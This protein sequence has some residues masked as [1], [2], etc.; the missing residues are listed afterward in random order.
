M[1]TMIYI[2]LLGRLSVREYTAVV[3]GFALYALETLLL[4]VISFLPKALIRY[5]YD[6]SR[7]AFHRFIL[8]SEPG[9]P[10]SFARKLNARIRD[11]RDFDELCTIW[12]YEHEEHVVM[13]ADGYIL[14]LH[15]LPCRKGELRTRP[16]LSTGKPV[17]YLHHGL[18]M[19]RCVEASS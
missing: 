10:K 13:T 8:N 18:M 5:F 12:G 15:R 7:L 4:V 17:V 11:A 1:A 19:N 2:P 9:V 16:G 3:A 6:L 14:T